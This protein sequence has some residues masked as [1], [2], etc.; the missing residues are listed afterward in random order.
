MSERCVLMFHRVVEQRQEDHDIGWASFLR[1]LEGLR[2]S[3]VATSLEPGAGGSVTVLTFD[4]GTADHLAVAEQLAA[5]GL[6][7]V[8]FVSAGKI[9]SPGYLGEH[10]IGTMRSL[11][12]V[13]A[14]HGFDHHRLEH[15]GPDA[16]RHEVADSRDVLESVV[17]EP[18]RYFAPT[19]GSH[20]PQLAEELRRAGYTASRSTRW[21]IYRTG[22]EPFDIPCVP[23]TELTLA[24]GWVAAA[25]ERRQLPLAMRATYAAKRLLPDSARTSVRGWTHRRAA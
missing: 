3:A 19:G 24:R 18:V 8:F 17:G 7:G 21:G 20:H 15:L 23:V 11:G 9:G 22:S 5:S 14:S 6:S 25:V 12:H 2:S 10:D 16:L 13:I 4:D 1:L